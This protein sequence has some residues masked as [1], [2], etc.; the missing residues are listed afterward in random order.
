MQN[1]R[2]PSYLSRSRH[3]VYYLRLAT[4]KLL[5]Q[6]Y[7]TLPCEI[8]KS[9]NTRCIREAAVRARKLALDFKLLTTRLQQTMT[10][11]DDYKG[12]FYIQP[13]ADGTVRY[14]FEKSDT[15]EEIERY[16]AAL[17]AKGVI[18]MN[19]SPMDLMG[20]EHPTKTEIREALIDAQ[21]I[22]H[23][24]VWLSDLILAYAEEMLQT[25]FWGTKNTWT[26][27]YRPI[28]RDF[29]NIVSRSKRTAVNEEGTEESIWDIRANELN[30]DHI[31][32][33]CD[34]MWKL[35]K[36]FGSMKGIADAKQALNTGLEPQSREN[37]FKRIR[38][39]KTFLKW[40]YQK[41]KLSQEL[42]E[43]LPVE[44][45]DKKRNTDDDGYQPFSESELKRIFERPNYPSGEIGW[46]FWIPLIALYTGARS[47][48]IAQ[49]L[50]TDFGT[51]DNVDC[52]II[53]D[54]EPDVDDSAPFPT[55]E[56][57]ATRKGKK[58]VKTAASRRWVPIHPKLVELGILRYRDYQKRQGNRRL[59]PELTYDEING[60]ARNVSRDFAQVTKSLGI[61]VRHKKVFHSFR[62]TINGRL[63][64][65]G[66]P[67][68]QRDFIL[69]HTISS[70]N[71]KHYA[72]R[73]EDRPF[74]EM[75]GWLSK[76][77][78]GLQ[79]RQWEEKM[80]LPRL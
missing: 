47:N 7:P 32:A 36:N 6:A 71:I 64:K 51:I 41:R 52:F 50:V 53:L 30:E 59:F 8:R 16:I 68:E 48:E 27:T 26:Q 21:E 33:Y 38:M 49:L 24:G 28:L 80:E 63:I 62:A 23:G 56:E 72:K 25:K 58:S 29:R 76:I 34:A 31:E 15:P 13:Q 9:L 79:L 4:P 22:K 69:G 1:I 39:T 67:P 46:K 10:S 70:M 73:I 12:Q 66:T 75:L 2:I 74:K 55:P 19:P 43:L 42:D 5:K 37:A 35:P 44:Q 57:V 60:Y 17:I 65:L 3:G 61:W 40:A 78:F 20:Y 77:D 18:P 14:H 11:K 54:L 45:V